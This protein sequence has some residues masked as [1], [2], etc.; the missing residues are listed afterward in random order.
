MDAAGRDFGS[1]FRHFAPEPV[2]S[3]ETQP[4]RRRGLGECLLS[5]DEWLNQMAEFRSADRFLRGSGRA[6]KRTK[7]ARLERPLGRVLA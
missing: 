4:A 2:R 6:G 1:P 7:Q 3:L 5:T